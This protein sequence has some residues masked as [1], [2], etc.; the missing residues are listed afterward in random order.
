[1]DEE[2]FRLFGEAK[3]ALPAYLDEDEQLKDRGITAISNRFANALLRIL[4]SSD[5][6]KWALEW[7]Q[8]R[9]KPVYLPP[10]LTMSR[11]FFG[12]PQANFDLKELTKTVFAEDAERIGR[13][14][15]RMCDDIYCGVF[16][17]LLNLAHAGL[18][19]TGMKV[20]NPFVTSSK[21]KIYLSF[22]AQPPI[23]VV[24]SPYLR[25]IIEG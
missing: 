25:Q 19:Q 7:E 21:G 23:E 3:Q 20:V 24:V 6:A 17:S 16:N 10:Y 11:G 22:L 13:E 9:L 1:M 15:P 14:F 12:K 5:M 4:H 18:E 8:Y 2:V